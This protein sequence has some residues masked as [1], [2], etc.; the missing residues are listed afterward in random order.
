MFSNLKQSNIGLF[1]GKLSLKKNGSWFFLISFI[2]NED[3]K[4]KKAIEQI[5]LEHS[6]I[7]NRKNEG[8]SSA[9]LFQWILK[10]IRLNG[11]SLLSN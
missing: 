11:D 8:K 4:V 1:T 5:I 3:T 7:L 6:D 10:E 9:K 2:Q